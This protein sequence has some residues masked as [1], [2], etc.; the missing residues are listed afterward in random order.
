VNRDEYSQ[1]IEQYGRGFELLGA[2]VSEVAPE[3]RKF[4]PAPDEWSIDEIL[5]H[6]ADSELMGV[7]RLYK[8]IAE[9]GS[10]LMAYDSGIWAKEMSYQNQDVEEALQMFQVARRRTYHLLRSL[11]DEV[12]S[13][14][15]IH[16][17]NVHPEYGAGYRLEKWLKIYI[18]HVPEHV[19]QL[20]K[21]YQ[22]WES[23]GGGAKKG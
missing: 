20:K 23:Q 7:T 13:H 5:V 6:M 16:P 9:P 11:T 10:T 4:K 15:A 19:E 3:A 1:L 12:F 21:V 17:E 2:A 8:L 18:F 22:L 14:S